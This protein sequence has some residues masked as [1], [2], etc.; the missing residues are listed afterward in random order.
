MSK[1]FVLALV[2]LATPLA[3]Q[4]PARPIVD[5]VAREMGG[6]DKIL[7]VRTL[8][9]E[10][11]GE[12]ASVGQN[13]S[14]AAPLNKFAVTRYSRLIDFAN[15]RWRQDQTREPR[16]ATANTAPQRQR[17][18]FDSVAIDIVSDTLTRRGSA[19]ASVDRGNEFFYH[20]I[21]LMQVALASGTE[22]TEHERRGGLHFIR[23]NAAG[24]KFAFTVDPRTFLPVSGEKIVYHPMLGDIVLES[25]F[26]DWQTVDGVRVPMR[27]VQRL[28]N[29]PWADL[30]FSTVR[31][32]PDIGDIAASASVKTAQ[33]PPVTVN[34]AVDSV[35]PGIWHLTGGTHHSVAIEMSDHL[36][37]VEAPLNDARTL[38]VIEKARTL[39]PR[40]PIR[41][42]INTHHHFD[43]SG[44]VRAA[45]SEGLPIITHAA[46]AAF[47]RDIAKR[48]HFIVQDAQSKKKR[49][50]QIEAVT[51]RK[52]LG[53]GQR[54]VELHEI[55]GSA[56]SQ[57][58]I[59]AYLPAERILI[60]AD[61]WNPPAAGVTP[62]PN[63]PFAKGLVENIDRLGLNVDR[64]VPIHGPV[65]TMS[66]LRAAA[67]RS[68]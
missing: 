44:G 57:S 16:F 8:A 49:P 41:A 67:A 39:R 7:A 9:L 14:P 13:L 4:R 12:N 32:N 54:T 28:D 31:L 37:L 11:A 45:I 53:S 24:N 23:M 51:T 52:V 66:D 15:K 19:A 20:P 27:I 36:L 3:A 34:V 2:L 50:A 47:Y 18:G 35:A 65:V 40:K 10:G 30:R 59:V 1:S 63:A 43:H 33:L 60:Q 21:G 5:R 48:Q 42:V 22:L 61:L 46:N 68:N 56:H 17:I 58:I 38:A 55:R 6:A 29:M 26:S 64:I 25:R 62:P